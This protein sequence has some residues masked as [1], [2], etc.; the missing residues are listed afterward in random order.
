MTMN[1]TLEFISDSFVLTL[2]PLEDSTEWEEKHD[3]LWEDLMDVVSDWEN[4]QEGS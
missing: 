4:R 2:Q 3:E 1:D